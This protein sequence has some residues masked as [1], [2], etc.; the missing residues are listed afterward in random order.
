MKPDNKTEASI[1][2][3]KAEELLKKK[4]TEMYSPLSESEALKLIHELEVQQ[5]ELQ[6]INE[7]LNRIKEQSENELIKANKQLELL[8]IHQDEIKENE[9]K[10]ISREIH[11][12]LGQS[13]S[14]LKIDL[15]WVAYNLDDKDG[16]KRKIKG[17]TAIVDSTIKTVQ[18]ISSDLRPG[19]LDDLGLV[20]AMEWYCQEFENRTR[21]PCHFFAGSFEIDDEKITLALYRILQEALTNVMRHSRAT[22]VSVELLHEN[23]S[24]I[25]QIIDNG[26]GMDF[27]QIESPMSLGIK[28]I[29]E[30]VRPFRGNL[31]ITATKN[32]G[33]RLVVFIPI[34]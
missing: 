29:V 31:Q 33:T 6:L 15:G 14:A 16:L 2:R 17:M 34:K 7:E 32:K 22:V 13:L 24:L 18:K 27:H 9:R 25:L 20:P 26:I 11:D 30:R 1:L 10:A 5:V 12:E 4:E 19:M 23:N 8:Y 3:Q 21:I 28:G